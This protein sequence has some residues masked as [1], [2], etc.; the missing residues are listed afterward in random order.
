MLRGATPSYFQA[1]GLGTITSLTNPSGSVTQSY[2]FDSFGVRTSG[3]PSVTNAFQY[4]G[5]ELDSETGWY[6]YR[7]RYYAPLLGRFLSEDPVQFGADFNFYRYAYN[8]PVRLADPMGLSPRDV[9]RIRQACQ[10]CTDQLTA[11]NLRSPGSGRLN[12][13]WND[14]TYWFTPHQLCYGQAQLTQPC[15]ENPAVPYDDKWTFT[16]VSVE[17]GTHRVVRG[18]NLDPNDPVVFCDPWRNKSWT[19]P[20]PPLAPAGGGAAG[21]W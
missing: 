8:S 10:K 16:V 9:Q 3:A 7:A 1:D 14:F 2:T 17:W 12:G 18:S 5:R 6:Y 20:K 19:A 4:T 15:L 21:G 13:W 11:A